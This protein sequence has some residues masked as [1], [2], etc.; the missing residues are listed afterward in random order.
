MYQVIIFLINLLLFFFSHLD[1]FIL[2]FNNSMDLRNILPILAYAFLINFVELKRNIA[3][4]VP[5]R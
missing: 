3:V 2:L 5:L 1:L 4:G